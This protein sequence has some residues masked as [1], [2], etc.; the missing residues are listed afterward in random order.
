M[1]TKLEIIDDVI[2]NGYTKITEQDKK[3]G[4][5]RK[6]IIDGS[7]A[8]AMR[9]VYDALSDVNKEK[10]LSMSWGSMAS[11]AWKRVSF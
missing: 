2:N 11:F 9:L 7:S 5:N 8:K 10:Y 1:K 3:T 4:K 6:V